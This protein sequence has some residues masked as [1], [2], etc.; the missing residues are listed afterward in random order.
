MA[1]ARPPVPTADGFSGAPALHPALAA[2]FEAIDAAGV[3]WCLLRG[4][5]GLGA[6]GGDVDLLVRAPDLPRL[7]RALAPL[8]FAAVPAW[9]HGSHRFF[10]AP[11]EAS[12]DWFKLDVVTELSYGANQALATDVAAEC[13]A[14]RRRTGSLSLLAPD[15]GF[16]SLLLHCLLDRGDVPA[17]HAR[18]LLAL[19]GSARADGPLARAVAPFCPQQWDPGRIVAHAAVSN[20]AALVTVGRELEERWA[21]ARPVEVRRRAAVNRAARWAGKV[22]KLLRRNGVSIALLGP[23]GSG[24][25]S[26]AAGLQR[27][28]FLPVRT[29]YVGLYGR[30]AVGRDRPGPLRLVARLVW[31][32]RVSLAAR[33]H[34]ARG[35]LVVF[36]RHPYEVDAGPP[37]RLGLGARVRRFVVARSCVAPD[38]AVL[39]DAPAEVMYARKVE[40]TVEELEEQRQRL[41][42]LRA[43]LPALEVVD[44]SEPV[45]LVRREITRRVWKTYAARVSGAEV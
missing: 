19:V 24:K 40:H 16:W 32:W 20:W 21:A 17:H 41:H 11:D 7:A 5:A 12:D 29:L 44:A 39:L 23:D 2:A 14:R 37:E 4:E 25:S 22:R 36:D 13:L 45:E 15:D 6:P 1:V 31:L 38:V 18:A 42:G 26:V 33:L 3:E 30:E 43:R 27:S 34:Q 10:V 28:F 35:G 9:G 8:G